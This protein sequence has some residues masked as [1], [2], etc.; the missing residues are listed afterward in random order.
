MYHLPRPLYRKML[1][2]CFLTPIVGVIKT[3]STLEVAQAIGVDKSTL[4]RW[5]YAGKLAEPTIKVVSNQVVRV[6]SEKDFQRAKKYREER[7]HK[8]SLRQ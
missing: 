6:W 3:F 4:L 8:R 1:T 5:L 7:Y 2:S